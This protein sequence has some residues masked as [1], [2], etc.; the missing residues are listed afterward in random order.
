[1]QLAKIENAEQLQQVDL[2]APNHN[3]DER[4]SSFP[5]PFVKRIN[6]IFCK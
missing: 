3:G 2:A 6:L 4:D 5:K 1:M